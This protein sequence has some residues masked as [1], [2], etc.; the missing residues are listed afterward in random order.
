[1]ALVVQLA[2]VA[3]ER[4]L[5]A[6]QQEIQLTLALVQIGDMQ[7]RER[8]GSSH[9]ANYTRRLRASPSNRCAAGPGGNPARLPRVAAVAPG[10]RS[11][12]LCEGTDPADRSAVGP[13]SHGGPITR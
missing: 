8:H 6:R 11:T 4:G 12:Y 5:D 9:R 7:P 13:P 1:M 2:E 3:L 10:A